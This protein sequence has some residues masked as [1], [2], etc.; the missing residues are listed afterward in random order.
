MRRERGTV[1]GVGQ[2]H[3]VKKSY[4]LL[5]YLK[6]QSEGKVVKTNCHA[7]F[8]TSGLKDIKGIPVVSIA[9]IECKL[10]FK[11]RLGFSVE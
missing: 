2:H 5:G 4:R 9:S 7:D 8:Q 11:G 6:Y 10:G 1:V 3:Q